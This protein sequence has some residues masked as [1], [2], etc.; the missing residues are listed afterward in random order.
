MNIEYLREFMEVGMQLNLSHAAKTLHVSQSALSKH[1]AAMEDEVGSTLLVRTTH[2]IELTRAGKLLFEDASIIIRLYDEMLSRIKTAST[3]TDISV[4]GLYKNA[5]VIELVNDAIS[6]MNADSPQVSIAY[7][8]E[9]GKSSIELLEAGEVDVAFTI[10]S[11]G[12]EVPSGVERTFLFDDPMICLVK[13]GH[14]LAGRGHVSVRDLGNCT[15][16]QPVGCHTTEH[17]RSTTRRI[18]GEYGIKPMQRPVFVRSMSEF[19]NVE[20]EDCVLIMERSMYHTQAFSED[21]EVLEVDEAADGGGTVDGTP[22]VFSFFA[23]SRTDTVKP[24]V[25]DFVAALAE[26]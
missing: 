18:F 2:K 17:G 6:E 22:A 15:I 10:L 19:A 16:L 26:R 23:L 5:S 24:H 13:G 14:P 3:M 21:Y 12:D 9:S 1:I 7:R 11:D 8:A 25:A 4:T 20:N